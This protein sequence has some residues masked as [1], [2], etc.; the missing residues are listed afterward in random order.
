M[1]NNP[2]YPPSKNPR[3]KTKQNLNIEIGVFG[4]FCVLITKFLS[5]IFVSCIL[6]WLREMQKIL[7]ILIH[8]LIMRFVD[9]VFFMQDFA[10]SLYCARIVK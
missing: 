3:Q 10:L 5:S 7:D 8:F 2:K 1:P 6:V 4:V 9:L